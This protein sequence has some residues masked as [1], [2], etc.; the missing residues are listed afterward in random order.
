M[1]HFDSNLG[2]Y[3]EGHPKPP[4]KCVAIGANDEPKEQDKW[5][6]LNDHSLKILD[7]RYAPLAHGGWRNK[8]CP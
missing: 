5:R 6:L 3:P 2:E 7:T 8:V 4:F 1:Q